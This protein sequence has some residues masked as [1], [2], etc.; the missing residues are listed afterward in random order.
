MKKILTFLCI[1]NA[2]LHATPFYYNPSVEATHEWLEAQHLNEAPEKDLPFAMLLGSIFIAQVIKTHPEYAEPFQQNFS[3]LSQM[4]QSIFLKAFSI[5]KDENLL[6]ELD[7]L[8]FKSGDDF[9]FIIVSFLATGDPRFLKQVMTFLNADP[10]LLFFSY[11]WRNRQF[12]AQLLERLTGQTQLPD[13]AEFLAILESWPQN[14]Q[15][16]FVLK[17]AAWKCL[18]II[19]A[20]DPTAEETIAQLCES[21]PSLDYQGTLTNLLE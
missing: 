21:N 16:L 2:L 10:E 5:V 13:E 18:D 9:D 19:M 6:S 8:E 12:L 4:E 1:C 14:K 7:H 11:E 3:D 15:Q 20:E 17:L